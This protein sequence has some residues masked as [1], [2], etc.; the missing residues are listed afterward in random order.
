MLD[1]DGLFLSKD[2]VVSEAKRQL[3]VTS[4]MLKVDDALREFGAALGSG[5]AQAM[6]DEQVYHAA[7]HCVLMS[8]LIRLAEDAPDGVFAEEDCEFLAGGPGVAG[9]PPPNPFM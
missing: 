1:V 8:A 9:P 2:S 4:A 7:L 3:E 6:D 5:D